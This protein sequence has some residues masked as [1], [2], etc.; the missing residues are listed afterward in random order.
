MSGC[1]IMFS[2]V[3]FRLD[4][5]MKQG[6]CQGEYISLSSHLKVIAKNLAEHQNRSMLCQVCMVLALRK[7]HRLQVLKADS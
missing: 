1:D 4:F 3:F 6:S 5:A 7:S 2:V